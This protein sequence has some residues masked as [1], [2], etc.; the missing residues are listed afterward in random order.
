MRKI[1]WGI[2][3]IAGFANISCKE[4]KNTA[5]EDNTPVEKPTSLVQP[6]RVYTNNE[7]SEIDII[8]FAKGDE[9]AVKL[10]KDG[11]TYELLAKGTNEKGNPI[12]TNEDLIWE[13]L[14]DGHSGKLSLPEQ[15]TTLYKEERK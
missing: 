7:G 3:I 6:K 10:I 2:I 12:F 13:I 15:K 8:Y 14:E 11:K 5:S 1:I 9:V 4:S